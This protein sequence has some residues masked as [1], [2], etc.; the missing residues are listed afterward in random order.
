M[1]VD[2]THRRWEIKW[3]DGSEWATDQRGWVI[4]A[5]SGV[6]VAGPG[7][8]VTV[9]GS[10]G[11][12]A[13]GIILAK[14]NVRQMDPEAAAAGKVSP[15]KSAV[16]AWAASHGL[17]FDGG[18]Q[19]SGPAIGWWSFRITDGTP[20]KQKADELAGL[21]EVDIAVRDVQGSVWGCGFGFTATGIADVV[22]FYLWY[23]EATPKPRDCES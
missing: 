13:E 11:W 23:C 19:Y 16:R 20:D 3:K 6:V 18:R 15:P 17:E 9:E 4:K 14:F 22:P 10:Q 7:D 2:D 5:P 21:P 12:Y 1:I 8:R